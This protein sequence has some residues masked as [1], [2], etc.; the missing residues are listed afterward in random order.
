MN[1]VF[2]ASWCKFCDKAKEVLDQA[3]VDYTYIDIDT[4]EGM[5]IMMEK[6]DHYLPKTIP[7]IFIDD[8]YIGGYEDLLVALS[9]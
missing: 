7:Q 2:G 1:I 8:K 5:G 9:G 3:E 4:T 6:F